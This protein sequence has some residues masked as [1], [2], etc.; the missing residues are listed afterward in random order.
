MI[1]DRVVID[2]DVFVG[3]GVV[4][5]NDLDPRA[6]HK[7]DPSRFLPTQV[8]RGATVGAN[9]TIVCGI[10]L[11]QHA[12][13][14]A[15]SVVTHDVAAHALVVGNPA[16]RV[17]WVCEC[18]ERLRRHAGVRGGRTYQLVGEREGLAPA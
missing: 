12:F 5:T 14:G 11:G 8:R 18:G 3:P 1:W 10:E 7:K 6:A 17:G 15:G 9:A 2:D 16:R 13:V 4:F